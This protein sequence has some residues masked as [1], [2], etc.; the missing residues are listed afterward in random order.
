M[1][2]F[3]KFHLPWYWMIKKFFQICFCF[4]LRTVNNKRTK[5]DK[6]IVSIC[7]NYNVTI[8]KYKQRLL[9]NPISLSE[10]GF[11]SRV[12][13][14]LQC[15]YL[16][17]HHYMFTCYFK[18]SFLGKRI[19]AFFSLSKDTPHLPLFLTPSST[20]Q[21]YSTRHHSN[22][23]SSLGKPNNVLF[24]WCYTYYNQSTLSI[25]TFISTFMKFNQNTEF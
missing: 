6:W 24:W 20:S 9:L 17:Y 7:R 2:I 19:S 16:R 22:L 14:V 25:Y 12:A 15:L 8:D 4:T 1:N 11:M 5:K 10:K 23:L 3:V 13:N 18:K 21:H